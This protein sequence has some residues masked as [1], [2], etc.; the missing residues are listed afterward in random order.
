MMVPAFSP[1]SPF[2]FRWLRKYW[3]HVETTARVARAADDALCQATWATN[4]APPTRKP[5][6]II[7]LA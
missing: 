1:T 5:V 6:V 7:T 2:Q 4:F 3:L